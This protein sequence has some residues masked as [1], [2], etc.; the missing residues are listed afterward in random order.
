MRTSAQMASFV[1]ATQGLAQLDDATC[2]KLDDALW[3]NTYN[4]LVM[5]AQVVLGMGATP[6]ERTAFFS[7]EQANP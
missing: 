2:L 5:H 1:A 6:A 7:A 4:A 3:I